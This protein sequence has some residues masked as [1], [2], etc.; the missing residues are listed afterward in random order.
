MLRWA[1]T[2]RMVRIPQRAYCT[3]NSSAANEDVEGSKKSLKSE[4]KVANQSQLV[5]AAF[6]S[7]KEL[8]THKKQR[9]SSV[10]IAIDNARNANELLETAEEP[11]TRSQALKVNF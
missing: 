6:A 4:P 11:I 10:D 3:V 5:A 8:S 7:L 9:P 2:L 1:N